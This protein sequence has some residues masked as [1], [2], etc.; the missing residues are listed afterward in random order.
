MKILVTGTAGFIG[1]H[2]ANK[3][4]ER[5]DKVVGLDSIAYKQGGL[6]KMF[7]TCPCEQTRYA[8]HIYYGRKRIEY[9]TKLH[10]IYK[11][12]YNYVY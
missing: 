8:V 9:L 2:L 12:D 1:S 4:L 5:G 6:Y 11:K 7:W 10:Y 3:L